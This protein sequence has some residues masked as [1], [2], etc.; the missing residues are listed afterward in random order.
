MSCS[1]QHPTTWMLSPGQQRFWHP[2][3]IGRRHTHKNCCEQKVNKT[4][5]NIQI[6]SQLNLQG[7]ILKFM[8]SLIEGG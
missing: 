5:I 2:Q 8:F 7:S 1:Q 4:N 3:S 6:H